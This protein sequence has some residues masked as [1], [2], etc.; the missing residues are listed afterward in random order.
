MVAWVQKAIEDN[1]DDVLLLN[2]RQ[3]KRA[4][5]ATVSSTGF[6]LDE[7]R[8]QAETGEFASERARRVWGAVEVVVRST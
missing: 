3:M 7:L 5:D 4:I 6:T 2:K 1:S 8:Q